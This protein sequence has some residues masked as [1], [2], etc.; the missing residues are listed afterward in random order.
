MT[1]SIHSI[2]RT[3]CPA[4][5]A[6]QSREDQR[7]SVRSL[8]FA[9]SAQII[10]EM[11]NIQGSLHE[12]EHICVYQTGILILHRQNHLSTVCHAVIGLA[13]FR[14]VAQ[15]TRHGTGDRV[16]APRSIAVHFVDPTKLHWLHVHHEVDKTAVL[17]YQIPVGR[18]CPVWAQSMA[19][20][21]ATP[22]A[23]DLW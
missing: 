1:T 19:A 8:C 2:V 15:A 13:C 17:G 6:L 16:T 4:W 11:S 21:T 9:S 3:S 18:V 20:S 23:A 10:K 5:M 14:F 12:P 7:R 22:L